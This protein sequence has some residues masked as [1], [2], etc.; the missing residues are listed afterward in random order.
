[1]ELNESAAICKEVLDQQQQKPTKAVAK[2]LDTKLQHLQR[3]I[4]KLITLIPPL[5]ILSIREITKR[6]KSK[7]SLTTANEL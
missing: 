2:K 6:F 5:N 7:Y 4:K 1:V 3:I